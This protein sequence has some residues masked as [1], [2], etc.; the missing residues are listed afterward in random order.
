MQAAETDLPGAP[1][2]L[3][4]A[5]TPETHLPPL[6]PGLTVD[7]AV[8][9]GGIAGL[10]A[11]AL[12]V[13]AGKSVAVIEARR[14]VEGVTGHT[15]AKLTSLHG[16]VYDRLI[17][18]FG[19]DRARAYAEANQAAIDLVESRVQQQG[20]DCDFRRTDAYTC[21]CAPDQIG[22]V[23]AEVEAALRVGLPAAFTHQAP[24][25]FPTAAAVRLTGQARFHPRKYLLALAEGIREAGGRIFEQ[26]R[27]LDLTEGEPCT[28][29]TDRGTL[30]AREVIIAT[31]FPS[32]DRAL[33]FSRLAPYRSYVLAVR[34]DGPVPEGMFLGEDTFFSLRPHPGPQG[35]LLLIGGEKHKAGQGGDTIARYRRV[36]EWARERFPVASVEYRWSTQDNWTLD[37]V[38]YIGRAAP[39]NEHLYVATGFAGWGMTGGTVAGM[40]LRDLITGKENRWAELYDPNRVNRESLSSFVR[41]N[42]DVARHFVGDRLA[43]REA[44]SLAPGEGA[45]EELDGEKVAAYRDAGGTLH[46]FKPYCTH[47]GCV[48][49]WNPAEKSW[50]CPCHGSRFA[51]E[52]SVLHGPAVKALERVA[53]D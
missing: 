40:L 21:V 43:R 32:I 45:V 49:N 7:V 30:S 15:T 46:C 27:A 9:G 36:E 23:E 48:L 31:H 14:I 4:L 2:S 19:E 28:V 16:L 1:T 52:G 10:T 22:K 38:P 18:S 37:G 25:P 6:A 44:I 51:A 39:G 33:Y 5:T 34:L 50:D 8:L 29:E 24:L 26:T 12:L 53:P 20:I 47:M 42:A 35:E 3:W 13:E 11:A 17:R 41:E